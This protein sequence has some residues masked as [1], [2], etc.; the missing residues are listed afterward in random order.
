MAPDFF[1]FAM[2][3]ALITAIIG[4][5]ISL[6]GSGLGSIINT[7]SRMHE[8]L[9]NFLERKYSLN[10]QKAANIALIIYILFAITLCYLSSL[11][12]S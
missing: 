5:L 8:F 12:N 9:I 7:F 10:T 1:I 6:F 2:A 3:M 4:L 11:V